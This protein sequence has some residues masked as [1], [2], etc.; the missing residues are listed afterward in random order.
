[1]VPL[2]LVRGIEDFVVSE[3]SEKLFTETSISK[4]PPSARRKSDGTTRQLGEEDNYVSYLVDRNGNAY[5]PYS[6]AWRYLG[7]Y[8]DCD[9]DAQGDNEERFLEGD[10]DDDCQ[11]TVLWAAVSH[12][13]LCVVRF[14]NH[15]ASQTFFS[16]M[17]STSIHDTRVEL[18]ESTSFTT[19]QQTLGIPPPVKHEDAREWI[20]TN[21]IRISSL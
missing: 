3:K 11:R 21:P 16:N 8:I 10:D 14:K 13:T 5:E 6:L 17:L 19:L 15:Y 7:M 9:V 2:S 12:L 20:V 1:M 18:L 4:I